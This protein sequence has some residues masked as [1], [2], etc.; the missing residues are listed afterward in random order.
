LISSTFA[1][2]RNYA[3]VS[4]IVDDLA[5]QIG[6]LKGVNRSRRRM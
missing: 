2:A 3:P 6:L 5:K 4:E 1:T